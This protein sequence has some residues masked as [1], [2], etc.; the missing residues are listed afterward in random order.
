MRSIILPIALICVLLGGCAAVDSSVP[1]TPSSAP[2]PAG[3]GVN[4][5]NPYMQ[6]SL[7]NLRETT[8]EG[9]A[10]L[11]QLGAN[12]QSIEGEARHR[13]N[14]R[15]EIYPLVFGDRK[16]PHE[17]IVILNFSEPACENLWKAVVEASKSLSPAQCKIAVYGK[18]RENYGT[19]LMG[20]AIWLA[21]SRPGSA[22]SY[23]SYALGRWNAVKTAQ[24][25]A[26]NVKQFTNEYDAT[27]TAEDF[28]IHY[29]YLMRL[30]PPVPDAQQPAIAKY[31]Y[32]AGNVNMYQAVQVCQY[33]GVKKL[34]TVIVDGKILG[35]VTAQNIL[36][37][38]K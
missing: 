38:L 10:M 37:A 14:W 15:E 34:P 25:S 4:V 27:A 11:G 17:I 21:H 22:M 8:S 13:K 23:L 29:G 31:C 3:G 2:V 20:L 26:G 1:Q 33:Y 32:D 36:A 5:F 9:Q 28:P 7:P 12:V 6:S 30:N 16:A 24:K 19:D 35:K 18:S